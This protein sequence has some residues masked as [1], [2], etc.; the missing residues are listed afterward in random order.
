MG[1]RGVPPNLLRIAALALLLGL[2]AT[3]PYLFARP[4]GAPAAGT[5]GVHTPDGSFPAQRVEGDARLDCW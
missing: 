2:A 1:I 3:T 4:T 5:G